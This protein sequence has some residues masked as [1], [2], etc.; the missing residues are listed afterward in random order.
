MEVVMGVDRAVSESKKRWIMSIRTNADGR[1]RLE[2]AAAAN[3]RNLSEEIESRLQRSFQTYDDYGGFANA[4]FVNLLG[5]TI[6][7]IEAQTGKSW[8]SNLDTYDHVRNAILRELELRS[9]S[10]PKPKPRPSKKTVLSF[11][12]NDKPK[13]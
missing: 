9:P 7:D 10:I 12:Y 3:G 6:R 1:S 4:A 2:E 8:R 11:G 5:A 13:S